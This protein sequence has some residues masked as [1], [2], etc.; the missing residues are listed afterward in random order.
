M[1]KHNVLHGDI[2][3]DNILYSVENGDVKIT[4]LGFAYCLTEQK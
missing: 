3:S 1:H 2:K 4:E